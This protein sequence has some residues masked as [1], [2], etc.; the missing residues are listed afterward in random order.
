[1]NRE[2]DEKK[3]KVEGLGD[4][5]VRDPGDLEHHPTARVVEVDDQGHGGRFPDAVVDDTAVDDTE[6]HGG[7]KHR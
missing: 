3:K 4:K 2:I 5:L 7:A 1:M 6:G